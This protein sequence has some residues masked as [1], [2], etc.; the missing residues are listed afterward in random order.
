MIYSV[1]KKTFDQLT[2]NVTDKRTEHAKLA[3][4]FNKV[5]DDSF[6][7]LCYRSSLRPL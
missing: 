6:E 3:S 1:L 7:Y 2:I 5:S 4:Q